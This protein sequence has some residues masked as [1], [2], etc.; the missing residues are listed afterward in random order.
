MQKENE[1]LNKR[2]EKQNLCIKNFTKYK[3]KAQKELYQITI[4]NNY[5]RIEVENIKK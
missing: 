1:D 3:S 2:L 4:Q 5:I